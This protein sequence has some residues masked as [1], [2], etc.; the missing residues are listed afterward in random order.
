MT[1]S[2][3]ARKLVQTALTGSLGTLT[4]DSSPFVSLVTVA[5]TSPTT[6]V[7]LLSGLAKHTQNLQTNNRCSLLLIEHV[8]EGGDPLQGAR[9]TVVGT[10]SKLDRGD[11]RLARTTF[12][13]AHP[14]ASMYADFG[15]FSFYQFEIHEAHLVAG[16]G[17]IKTLS[18]DQL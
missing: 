3:P 1:D 10:V 15:D 13:A 14:S 6:V 8:G 16:F 17:K 4:S 18:P 2:N 12:L 5:A 9:L 11:D 7:M